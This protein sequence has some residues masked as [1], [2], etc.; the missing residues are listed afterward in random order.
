MNRTQRRGQKQAD[1]PAEWLVRAAEHQRR[2]ETGAA[3]HLYKK[4]LT[5]RP[6]HAGACEALAR[7]YLAQGKLDKASQQFA[8][9]AEIMPQT[10]SPF[11]TVLDTLKQLN[12]ALA[13]ALANAR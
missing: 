10:L 8:V 12:P 1:V 3:V 2:G 7:V 11:P 5:A 4:I 9:L 13:A 6:D